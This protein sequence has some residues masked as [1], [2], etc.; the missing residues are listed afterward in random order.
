MLKNGI[1]YTVILITGI[2]IAALLTVAV[3]FLPTE[4]MENNLEKSVS[5]FEREGNYHEL[6]KGHLSTRLDN[7]TDSIMLSVSIYNGNESPVE[8]AMMGYRYGTDIHKPVDSLIKQLN[9]DTDGLY[10]IPYSSYW[11]GYTVILKPLLMIFD[12]NEIRMTNVFIQLTLFALIIFLMV[13]RKLTKFIFP[14][15]FSIFL[16]SPFTVMLSLQ[17]SADFYIFMAATAIILL[18]HEYIKSKNLYPV[19]FLITGMATS[20]F[21]L[22]TCPILT[23]GFPLVFMFIIDKEKNIKKIIK[24]IL[25]S[26]ILWAVG[27]VGLWAGKWAVGSI[28]TDNNLFIEAFR[29]IVFRASSYHNASI[30][31]IIKRNILPL[32][33]TYKN[34]MF[35]LSYSKVFIIASV[36]LWYTITMIIS[37]PK[38]KKALPSVLPFAIIFLLPFLWFIFVENHSY[39][40]IWFTFRD[41]ALTAF[42]GLCILIKLKNTEYSL[43]KRLCKTQR[44]S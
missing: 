4:I 1:K 18:K 15:S 3:Q 40:H 33:T 10:S 31:T 19:L 23:I 41:L 8:K 21:D 6:I 27:Y 13:K 39:I 11:H 17:Y 37:R 29:S 2:F 22:L 16:M 5:T 42:A 20:F 26:G 25:F 30:I 7:Y 32:C 24:S 12:Y 36:T 44:R 38:L 35:C 14:F 28:L 34:K 9:S 43:F